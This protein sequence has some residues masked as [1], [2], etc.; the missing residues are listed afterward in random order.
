MTVIKAKRKES[1]FEVFHNLMKTR[2]EITD[3]LL[4]DFGY[5]HFKTVEKI[6]KQFIVPYSDMT[7]EEQVRYDR[8]MEKEM[9]FVTWYI[10]DERKAVIDCIR[11]I[12]KEV[13]I[14]NSIYPTC[15]M[16]LKER[17]LHQELALGHCYTLTQEL[18]YAM[19]TL[20][21]DVNKYIRFAE[22]INKEIK[23]IKSWRKSDN[24]F[25]RAFS[26]SSANFAN[27]NN[28]GNASNNNASNTNGV[29][30]DFD[31]KQQTN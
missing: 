20:P 22:M 26:N 2:K 7:T 6:Q 19:E 8:K 1:Q 25:K 4:R 15:E 3:L 16:E 24:K 5:N 21:V 11:G 13:Y 10:E 14:A 31:N 23:L 12:T 9:A 27:V 18:Q 28:N 30:P 17:R 29:R